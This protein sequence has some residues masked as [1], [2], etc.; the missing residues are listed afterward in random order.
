MADKSTED[1]DKKIE[2]ELI[3]RIS[4]ARV[5]GDDRRLTDDSQQKKASIWTRK[6]FERVTK[7]D[8]AIFARQLSLLLDLGMT[9]LRALNIIS[10]RTN[11]ARMARIITNIGQRVEQGD[12]LSGAM[13]EYQQL[14]G[15][16]F[17]VSVRAGE[18]SGEI[19]RTLRQLADYLEKDDMFRGKFLKAMSFPL[20]TLLLASAVVVFL[21]I[22]VI[23]T[24]AEVYEEAGADLPLLTQIIINISYFL[25]TYWWLLVIAILLLWLIF[26]K[27]GK[28]LG[29]ER[30]FD[31]IKLRLPV[32]G[33]LF[34]KMDVFRFSR[35]TATMLESGVSI[36]TTLQ[37]A[38]KATG[39]VIVQDAI[40]KACQEIDKGTTLE[41][42]FR[43]TNAFPP[44]VI[45][46]I[47]VGEEVG[48]VETVL[49]K[50]A[51]FYERDVDDVVS[52]LATL[53][54]P[55]LTL[56]LG[57]IVLVIA[58]AMFMPYFKLSQLIR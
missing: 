44:F 34:V 38:A 56:L 55:I 1:R 21:L 46:M 12:T 9:L 45:D 42:S 52:N 17:L 23:P 33:D 43:K 27:S 10:K 14:F 54:E 2:K 47:G 48:S 20:L 57:G 15:E 5:F 49:R 6:L 37:I 28:T 13:A 30:V 51:D 50:I 41:N 26:R 16:F 29:L 58:L 35:I 40:L 7:R 39:N 3:E 22:F 24:F 53:L 8:L 31:T 4:N 19:G 25:K 11:N 36:L 32:F 18:E